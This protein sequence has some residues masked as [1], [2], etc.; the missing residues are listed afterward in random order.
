MKCGLELNTENEWKRPLHI[1]KKKKKKT[2][3]SF[4][5]AGYELKTVENVC[6]LIDDV[7]LLLKPA[8]KKKTLCAVCVGRRDKK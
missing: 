1:R 6:L 4:H 2:T 8:L 7:R 3:R 5:I